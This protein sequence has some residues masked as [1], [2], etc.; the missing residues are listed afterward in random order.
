MGSIGLFL[1]THRVY[2]VKIEAQYE[3]DVNIHRDFITFKVLV[4][5]RDGTQISRLTDTIYKGLSRWAEFD[6]SI[7]EAFISVTHWKFLDEGVAVGF[8]D[9]DRTRTVSAKERSVD[10]AKD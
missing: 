10:D 6:D 8:T 1:E 3:S 7:K 2:L 9:I 4:P 5:L